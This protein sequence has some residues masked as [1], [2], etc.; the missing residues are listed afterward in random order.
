L[1]VA[2]TELFVECGDIVANEIDDTLS[3]G[4]AAFPFF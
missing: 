4:V 1:A 3:L 2:R